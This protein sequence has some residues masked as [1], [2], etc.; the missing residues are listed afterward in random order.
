MNG[1]SDLDKRNVNL[2]LTIKDLELMVKLNVKVVH[3]DTRAMGTN[4]EGL[5]SLSRFV[6]LSKEMNHLRHLDLNSSIFEDL[7]YET[8]ESLIG[9][10]IKYLSTQ[11]FSI[12]TWNHRKSRYD[13]IKIYFRIDEDSR[14]GFKFSPQEFAL[15]K[16]LPVNFLHL[17]TLDLSSED[18]IIKFGEIMK[19]MQIEEID[20]DEEYNAESEEF[21]LL[22]EKFDPDGIY[23]T[24]AFRPKW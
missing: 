18:N 17:D 22:V 9:L 3:I 6:N 1:D 10:P 11:N 8:I 7:D 12:G 21:E 2:A 14:K 15:F 16:V 13:F 23:E 5:E 19:E 20:G 24:I 4:I